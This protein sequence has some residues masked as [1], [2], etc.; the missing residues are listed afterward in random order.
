MLTKTFCAV[1]EMTMILTTAC[2][3]SESPNTAATPIAVDPAVPFGSL[4]PADPNAQHALYRS[5]GR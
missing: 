3:L 4:M 1:I 5:R 2:T